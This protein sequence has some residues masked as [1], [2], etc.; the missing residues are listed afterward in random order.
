[1]NIQK[2]KKF[3]SFAKSIYCEEN[4][5]LHR[6]L[7]KGS[8]EEYLEKCIKSNFVSSV[9]QY[10]NK[11]EQGVANFVG[12][13]YGVATINGTSALHAALHVGGVREN[14]EVITQA[15]TFVATSNAILYAGA[16]PIFLDVDVDTMG[17]SPDALKKYLHYNA[18]KSSGHAWNK[19]TGKRISA[20]VPMHTYGMPCRIRQI[21]EICEEWNILLIEDSA[22]SLG[23]VFEGKHT[24][25]YGK[26]G[27][28][29]F[30]GNK[31]ISTGGGGGDR[32]KR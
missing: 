8:E 25:T 2:A 11:F 21:A 32:Y 1:M 3:V 12:S 30:N 24:G 17:L 13:S 26:M 14:D 10:V 23:S 15:L 28:F 27:I 7:F 9:G 4:I 29:S 5:P 22:E 16:N 20:C 19:Q 18:K 31:I 6:P